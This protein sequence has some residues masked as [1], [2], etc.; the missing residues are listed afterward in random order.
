AIRYGF[1]AQVRREYG[2]DEAFR[3]AF[4]Q[5]VREYETLRRIVDERID[6]FRVEEGI[7]LNEPVDAQRL[8]RW[9]QR[10][11]AD[12]HAREQAA[13]QR[14]NAFTHMVALEVGDVIKV[15][16]LTPHALQHGVRTV[17]FQTPV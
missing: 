4:L 11:P 12:I 7:G 9:L 1:D 2:D 17:E 10:I 8:K 15:A 16:T 3:C 13:R 5:S 14:M 6:G